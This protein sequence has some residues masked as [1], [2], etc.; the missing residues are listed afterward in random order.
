M[1]GNNVCVGFKQRL[2]TWIEYKDPI[3]VFEI[4][5]TEGYDPIVDYLSRVACISGWRD[6]P[7]RENSIQQCPLLALFRKLI[8][9]NSLRDK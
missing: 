3:E 1:D 5:S 6:V 7:H 4:K 9:I 8:K 2:L